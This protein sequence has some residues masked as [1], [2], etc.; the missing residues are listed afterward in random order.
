MML[1]GNPVRSAVNLLRKLKPWRLSLT[2]L[3]KQQRNR[4]SMKRHNQN[5]GQRSH[6][7]RCMTNIIVAKVR[8]VLPVNEV[9]NRKIIIMRME[10]QTENQ[11]GMI[12]CPGGRTR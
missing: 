10:H 2:I 4:V 7:R 11:I 6:L 5:P 3:E 12:A 1:L 8:K 9:I